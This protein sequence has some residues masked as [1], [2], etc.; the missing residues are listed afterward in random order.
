MMLNNSDVS[1]NGG[2]ISISSGSN[3]TLTNS[4]FSY[5]YAL[6]GGTI[7]VSGSSKLELFSWAITNSK[8]LKSGGAIYAMRGA[9][10]NLEDLVLTNNSAEV[11]GSDLYM[12]NWIVWI[13][14]SI[15]NINPKVTP[16]FASLSEFDWINWVFNNLYPESNYTS[17]LVLGGAI[18][19]S[20]MNVFTLY[21]CSFNNFKWM[22]EF[23]LAII[24]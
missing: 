1:M 5:G 4:T 12:D 22:N 23:Y 20:N 8:A 13:T 7:F 11:Y 2:F 15:L 19:A 24:D 6:N 17:D 9:E 21:N 16:V 10:I 14:Y 18:Y 3:I